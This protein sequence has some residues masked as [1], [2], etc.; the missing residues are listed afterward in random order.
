MSDVIN[1]STANNNSAGISRIISQMSI[2]NEEKEVTRITDLLSS[3]YH[4]MISDHKGNWGM[5]I[6]H[7]DWVPGVGIIAIMEY[8]TS[9]RKEAAIAYAKDW[10]HRNKDK[11]ATNKVINS[12]AP[13]AIFPELYRQNPDIWYLEKAKEIANWMLDEAPRT[14]EGAF[15]HTVTESAAF[16]EQIWA[17]TV[18]MAVLFLARYAALSG[19]KRVAEEAVRQT[20]LHI[21][22]L[23]EDE[24]GLLFHGW[25]CISRNHMSAARWARANA[26]IVLAVPMIIAELTDLAELPEELISRYTALAAGLRK[27]QPEDG[28]WHTVLDRPD[29]YKET[30]AS[31]GIACGFL[32]AVK[33]GLLEREYAE[34]ASLAL[35]GILP[36]INE[37]GAVLGV[38]GGTPVMESEQAYNQI[39][40]IAA[41]YGQGM[42]MMLLT[43]VIS[44]R[45][46]EKGS[47]EK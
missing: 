12:M 38:S 13:F 22:L 39:P 28:L 46:L 11:A 23:Q 40:Q 24:S 44:L 5:D 10:V 15:E 41:L 35:K 21:R 8:G 4:Y 14:R 2:V 45:R 32:K 33:I 37:D 26:W 6:D 25:N 19:D 17:D 7:W 16:P 18:F 20:L 47:P 42:T 30:S 3:M 34:A 29:F 43:E 9:L 36:L 27:F 31:A 1:S